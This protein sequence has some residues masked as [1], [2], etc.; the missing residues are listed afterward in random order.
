LEGATSKTIVSPNSAKLRSNLNSGSIDITH[1][2]LDRFP[3]YARLEVPELWC[4][5]EGELKIYHLQTGE[6][7]AAEMSLALPLLPIRELPQLIET[8]LIELPKCLGKDFAL[9]NLSLVLILCQLWKQ[10]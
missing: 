3:I 7:V 2:S 4:Y 1:K 6:Y 9:I 5:D 8:Q 10:S